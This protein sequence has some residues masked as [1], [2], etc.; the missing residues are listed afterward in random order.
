MVIRRTVSTLLACTAITLLAAP[1]ALTASAFSTGGISAGPL[2]WDP[3]NPATRTYYIPTIAPGG[4]FHDYVRLGNPN[5]DSVD[6]I[7]S[8]VDGVTATP[9]GAVYA[10][11]TDPVHKAGA[12]V[13]PDQTQLTLAAG[14]EA[15]VGFTVRVPSNATPGDHLAG[16]AVEN[17]HPTPGSGQISITSVV[18]TVVGVLVKVPGQ[19]AFDLEVGAASILPLTAQGLA[20]IVVQ[21]TDSGRL[22]GHPSLTVTL[23][24]PNGYHRTITRRLDTL[25]PGD[26]IGY[27]FPWPDTLGPGSYTIDV[28]GTGEGM[29]APAHSSTNATLKSGLQGVPSPGAA[30]APV[31]P[32]PAAATTPAWLLPVAAGGGG[33]LVALLG[34][35]SFLAVGLRRQ[36]Q[37]EVVPAASSTA[38]SASASAATDSG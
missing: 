13:T 4:T 22:L 24:G 37:K 5:T 2:H 26:T 30:A 23:S 17:A 35:V 10:N 6:L 3:A 20:S 9:S 15:Q 18:R 1:L 16:V 31:Q 29:A 34:A 27:P 28:S 32:A 8:G 14:Q 38:S 33:L 7:V 12:W 36:R 11:R 21:L 25:L 19:A